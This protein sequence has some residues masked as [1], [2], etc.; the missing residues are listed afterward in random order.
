MIT[1]LP[2]IKPISS[3]VSPMWQFRRRSYARCLHLAFLIACI[4][5]IQMAF[6]QQQT[7]A[8]A[9][10]SASSHQFL[11]QYCLGC[12]NQRVASA[13][14]MLDKLDRDHVENRPEVWEKVVRKLRAGMM[15]P[16]GM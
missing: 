8:A 7:S 14:L 5:C 6:G 2:L 11:N 9:S 3:T 1:R 13:G 4:P 12:H 15:P 10:P 16:S